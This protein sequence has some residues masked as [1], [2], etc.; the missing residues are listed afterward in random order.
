[1]AVS[2]ASG[3]L[4]MAASVWLGWPRPQALAEETYTCASASHASMVSLLMHISL[5]FSTSGTAF[6]GLLSS[7]SGK[8]FRPSRRRWFRAFIAASRLFMVLARRVAAAARPMA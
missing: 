2:T 6:S 4:P 5:K 8:A 7:T 3:S 1:M